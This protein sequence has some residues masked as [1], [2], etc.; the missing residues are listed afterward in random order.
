MDEETGVFTFLEEPLALDGVCA[1]AGVALAGVTLEGVDFAGVGFEGVD[2]PFG[3]LPLLFLLPG[4]LVKHSLNATTKIQ[5]VLS[6]GWQRRGPGSP[7]QR[8][9]G[10]GEGGN[11]GVR[12]NENGQNQWCGGG[13]F[14]ANVVW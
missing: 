10:S 3:V 1:L 8:H 11:T 7:H 13:C 14:M 12:G 4:I 5:F 2:F 9:N 6:K